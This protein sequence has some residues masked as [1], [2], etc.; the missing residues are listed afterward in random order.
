[1]TRRTHDSDASQSDLGVTDKIPRNIK[2]TA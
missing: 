1:M 2:T